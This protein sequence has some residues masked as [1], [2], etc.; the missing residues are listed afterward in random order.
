MADLG[1]MRSVLEQ[2]TGTA[3]ATPACDLLRPDKP[4]APVVFASPHS[5]SI[6]PADLVDKLRVPL[7]DLRRTED[8]FVDE[9]F[10]HAPDAGAS[11]LTANYARAYVDLNRDA[12]E[13][14]ANMFADGLPR[15]AG[16]PGVR[17]K[18]GLGCLPRIGAGAREIYA[19]PITRI[20]GARRL[21]LIHDVYHQT[22]SHELS[23]LGQSAP[24]TVLIDCHSMPSAQPGRGTA[25][26]I[27]L[28]DRFGSSCTSKLTSL[29]ERC[30]R[31]A[32]YS[33]SRNAPYAGG[34]TTRRYGRPRR[35]VHVL[36]IEVNRAL[37]LDEQS[38]EKSYD[39]QET[40]R[41]I[42]SIIDAI[43]AFAQRE[44]R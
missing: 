2:D 3:L 16:L 23:R 22:L 43:V 1:A 24:E 7:I 4:G 11:F 29:V 25:P 14:D 36:Q 6:Y 31:Q 33:V 39:F 40:K 26:D 38:V 30:F 9:L 12:R 42:D 13:L 21:D 35:G 28:G 34:Y 32:G 27:V 15:Q 41:I 10:A 44:L 5:G 18:A 19:T 8:A 37:Y 20:E 17:V